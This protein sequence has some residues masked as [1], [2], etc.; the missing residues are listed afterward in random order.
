M[1]PKLATSSRGLKI[2][3]QSL[4]PCWK[5]VFWDGSRGHK[6]HV[7]S[8]WHYY[9][10]FVNPIVYVCFTCSTVIGGPPYISIFF[11]FSFY[12]RSSLEKSK[13]D[14]ESF[15]YRGE[16][17]LKNLLCACQGCNPHE[18]SAIYFYHSTNTHGLDKLGSGFQ[19]FLVVIPI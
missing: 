14:G 19:K 5:A 7:C 4:C 2:Y 3:D 16:F 13:I 18:H 12:L 17:R 11:C 10:D 6:T 9:P 1:G 15:R 8:H